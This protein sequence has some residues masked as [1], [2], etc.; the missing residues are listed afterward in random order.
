MDANCD[1]ISAAGSLNE[2]MPGWGNSAGCWFVMKTYSPPTAL[3]S[4]S[5]VSG[6]HLGGIF[7][8]RSNRKIVADESHKISHLP[9]KSH[10]REQILQHQ[11]D[12]SSQS[13]QIS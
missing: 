7:E 11:S 12:K 1:A 10:S 5:P 13:P 4:I 8:T 6:S 9:F 3:S 2:L